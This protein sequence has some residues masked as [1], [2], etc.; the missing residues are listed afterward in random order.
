MKGKQ[1]IIQHDHDDVSVLISSDADCLN[2]FV[3]V[4][5]TCSNSN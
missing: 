1:T 5:L 4:L 2:F 3:F